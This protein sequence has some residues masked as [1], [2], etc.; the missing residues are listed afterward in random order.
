M[1]ESTLS[2]GSKQHEGGPQTR[3]L[4]DDLGIDPAQQGRPWSSESPPLAEIDELDAKAQDARLVDAAHA[5]RYETPI[6]TAADSSKLFAGDWPVVDHTED[7]YPLDEVVVVDED[8]EDDADDESDDAPH[9]LTSVEDE[10]EARCSSS[11]YRLVDYS[12][13]D[14]DDDAVELTTEAQYERDD[15][16]GVEGDEDECDIHAVSEVDDD[17]DTIGGLI[18]EA[19]E[20]K[21][22][23]AVEDAIEGREPIKK[24]ELRIAAPD[25]SEEDDAAQDEAVQEE[26]AAAVA[27]QLPPPGEIARLGVRGSTRAPKRIGSGR[28]VPARLTWKPGDPFAT[29]TAPKRAPFRWELMLTSACITAVCGLGCV[30]LLRNLLT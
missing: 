1:H 7:D 23:A 18:R 29:P 21:A 10:T 5:Q 12:D 14:E 25:E 26:M 28:L 19:I 27:P 9:A 13:Y 3:L 4:F 22:T 8:V 17:S 24:V 15:V 16:Y 2:R 6:E 30:W 20:A 11:V